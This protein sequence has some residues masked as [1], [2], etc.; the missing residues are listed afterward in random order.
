MKFLITLNNLKS[1]I[2]GRLYGKTKKIRNNYCK[3]D[4]MQLWPKEQ[5]HGGIHSYHR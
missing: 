3:R 1:Y 2:V 4:E 5:L